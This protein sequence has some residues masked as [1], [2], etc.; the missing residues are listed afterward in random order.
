MKLF[1]TVDVT[2]GMTDSESWHVI[3]TVADLCPSVFLILVLRPMFSIGDDTV[4]Y[5]CWT[6]EINLYFLLLYT[7]HPLNMSCQSFSFYIES[8]IVVNSAYLLSH[9]Q[10]TG[11]RCGQLCPLPPSVCLPKARAPHSRRYSEHPQ[12]ALSVSWLVRSH[13]GNGGEGGTR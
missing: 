4:R 5:A 7:L 13:G 9:L 1:I 2:Q 8:D 11:Q 12:D 3:R 10:G 6:I